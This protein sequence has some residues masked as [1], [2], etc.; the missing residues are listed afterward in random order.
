MTNEA[1][2]LTRVAAFIKDHGVGCFIREGKLYVE[3]VYT[4]NCEIHSNWKTITPSISAAKE[5]LNY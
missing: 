1:T 4:L 3:D 5:F 2:T